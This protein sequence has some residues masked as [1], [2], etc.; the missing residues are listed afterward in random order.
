MTGTRRAVLEEL[1]DGPV[2]AAQVA[3]TLDLPEAVVETHVDALGE[4]GFGVASTDKGY[5]VTDVP[6][7]GGLAV[8]FGLDAPLTVEY[9]DRIGS[10]NDRGRELAESGAA[11][12]VVL[13]DEQTGGR[14]RRS[15]EWSSPSGGVWMSVVCRP[16]VQP[17]QVSL[18]TFAVAVAVTEAVRDAGVD[19]AIKWPND[20]VVPGDDDRKLAGILTEAGGG[21]DH[22]SWVVIGTGI[23]ANVDPE[24]LPPAAT[25]VSTAV[26]PVDRREIVQQV[27]ETFENLRG[28][29]ETVR[30]RWRE[31]A[32]TLSRRVR[33]ETRRE[34]VRGEAVDVTA[35]GAL[36]VDTGA[37]RVVVH[38][39]DCEHLRPLGDGSG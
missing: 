17:D 21:T 11:D 15:R 18:L 5:A 14:G 1:A 27:L 29:P 23:N 35:T 16:E 7:F 20:V 30:A 19:A 39:G 38:T 13:A 3:D 9:H 33:V 24:A 22:P 36:V 6:E 28:E 8:A 31:L 32:A 37:E 12:V 2:R 10:T 34:T 25:S 26:G 4:A